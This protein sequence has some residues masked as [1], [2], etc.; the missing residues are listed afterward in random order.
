MAHGL[1][2]LPTPR[3]GGDLATAVV[4]GNWAHNAWYTNNVDP[5]GDPDRIQIPGEATN[6]EQR[7]LT[8]KTSSADCGT[9]RDHNAKKPWRAPGTAPILSPCG[10]QG[11]GPPCDVTG[12]WRCGS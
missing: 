12:A 9:S 2:T 3:Q 8:S 6:C 10:V 11:G 1:M 7:M 5:A 4:F